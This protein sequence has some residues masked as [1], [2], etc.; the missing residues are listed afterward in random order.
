[1]G[2]AEFC[3]V[4]HTSS[5]EF[6]MAMHPSSPANNHQRHWPALPHQQWNETVT[7]LHLWTQIVGKIRIAHTPLVNHWWNSTLAV[8]SRGLTTSLMPATTSSFELE[9][10][11]VDH[12]L[13]FRATDGTSTYLALR[14]GTTADF[15]AR[16]VDTLAGMGIGADLWPH[17]V[18]MPEEIRL[19][20]DTRHRPY[21]LDH[22]RS[23]WQALVEI[24]RVFQ[25]FRSRFIGKSSPVHFF[26]G[27]FDLAVTRFSGRTAPE[28]PGGFPHLPDHV[29]F[30]SYSYELISAGWWP[31][32]HGVDEPTFYSYTYPEPDGMLDRS[33]GPD[34]AHYSEALGEY[35]LPY[36][37]VRAA[38]S[39][40]ETLLE[41]LQST[42]EAASEAG[43][44]PR[45]RLERRYR[46]I[47][48]PAD[49]LTPD[50][51]PGQQAGP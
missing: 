23:L 18:E 49:T 32:G 47:Y 37:A 7:T 17:T 4:H 9:F 44:W 31:G 13:H 12:R 19:D 24:D 8:S 41:F 30:E 22:A 50:H 48:R 45:E 29:T 42:Y 2:R 51:R 16:V 21:E 5:R 15:Y 27:S 1:M 39:P 38:R 14:S 35:L 34:E 26:W 3:I 40:D 46:P 20:T 43:D 11:F 25:E 36:E 10:D 33:I 28:H 6:T